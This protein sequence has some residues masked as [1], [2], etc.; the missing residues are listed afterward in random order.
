MSEDPRN[1]A[2]TVAQR[3]EAPASEVVAYVEDFGNAPE[4]MVGVSGV[5]RLSEDRYRFALDGPAGRMQ[6]EVRVLEHT[7]ERFRWE[8]VSGVEGGGEVT[9]APTEDAPDSSCIVVYAGEFRLGGRLSGAARFMG[10]DKFARK[11]GERSLD[12]LKEI[13]EEGR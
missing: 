13:M 5:E 8:Y 9:V 10:L 4:W 11:M 6:P 12:Q 2:V 3:V 7:E 1:E